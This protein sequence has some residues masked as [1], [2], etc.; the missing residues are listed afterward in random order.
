MTKPHH[1]PFA[2]LKTA[3]TKSPRAD[4]QLDVR[5]PVFLCFSA[6]GITAFDGAAHEDCL[7]ADPGVYTAAIYPHATPLQVKQLGQAWNLHPRLVERL[8]K[9]GEGRP[10]WFRDVLYIPLRGAQYIDE[11]G[12][13]QLIALQILMRGEEMVIL[14]PDGVWLDGRPLFERAD[15]SLENLEFRGAHTDLLEAA[16]KQGPPGLTYWLVEEVVSSFMPA[17]EGLEEDQEQIEVQVFA[18]KGRQSE[19]IYKLNQEAAELLRAANGIG[20]SIPT[21]MDALA[22]RY[23]QSQAENRAH[24]GDL[25][26]RVQSLSSQVGALREALSQVLT[27]NATLVAERQNDDM[28]KISGWAGIAFAPTLVAGIYGMNFVG[29]PEL[30]WVHGYPIALAVMALLSGILFVVFKKNDWI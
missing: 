9:P 23:P 20:R 10:G 24:F 8:Q 28:K 4:A 13:V 15:P 5:P 2:Q 1:H 19:K 3:L 6:K 7:E 14:L 18:G 17:L 30:D 12:D 11:T 27:I 29:M 16:A 26:H 21:L 22:E 25:Q